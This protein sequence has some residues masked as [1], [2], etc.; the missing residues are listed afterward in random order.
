MMKAVQIHTFGGPDTLRLEEVPQ[1]EPGDG[2]V[3]VRVLAAGVNPADWKIREGLLGERAFP[4]T[5]GIDFSGVIESAGPGAGDFRPGEE[6]FGRVGNGSGSYAEFAVTPVNRIARKPA[7][8]DHVHA[9]ALPVAALT[10]WQALFDA[11]H[12]EPHQR[13]LIHAAA[14]GVGGFAVQLAKWKRAEVA[15]TASARNAD[16]L[17]KL[18]VDEF[19]DYHTV[20]FEERLANVDLV[21]D[22]VGG[23]T[24]QRSWNVLKRGGT[25]VSIVQ[26]PSEATAADFGVRS[27]FLVSSPRG[28]Q[29]ARIASLVTEGHVK[30]FVEKIFALAEAREAQ[31]LSQSGHT[32]GKIVL[33]VGD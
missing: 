1:P 23:E 7:S 27:V 2:E 13:V 25:L 10:A 30:V 21:F 22:T 8:M 9:A 20:K 14:G 18:G 15:A 24:Q 26:P 28:D 19:I 5:M 12:L 33:R 29:L 16:Y 32:R 4:C 17:H 6:V 31:I 11:G 3:L